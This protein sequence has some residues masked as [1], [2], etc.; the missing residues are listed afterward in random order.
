VESFYNSAKQSGTLPE[1]LSY[2]QFNGIYQVAVQNHTLASQ[3][4]VEN[5]GA[6]VHHF[7]AADNIA[8]ERS[9]QSWKQ[10]PTGFSYHEA[11]GGHESMM[12]GNNA[13]GLAARITQRLNSDNNNKE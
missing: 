7:T 4:E 8:G 9:G 6:C 3:Y 10:S 5:G 2:Q 12:Q 1:E 11:P 13:P